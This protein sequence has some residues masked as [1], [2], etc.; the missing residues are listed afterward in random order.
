MGQ[1]AGLASSDGD[2]LLRLY[3]NETGHPGTTVLKQL[4][5]VDDTSSGNEHACSSLASHLSWCSSDAQVHCCACGGGI[6]TQCFEGNH[7]PRTPLNR[8]AILWKEELGVILFI[9]VLVVVYFQTPKL[10]E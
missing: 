9:S 4:G 5:C 6:S 2:K 7:C 3:S 8:H 10:E 1:R